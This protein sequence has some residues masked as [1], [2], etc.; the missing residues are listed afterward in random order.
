MLRDQR[1]PCSRLDPVRNDSA[2]LRGEWGEKHYRGGGELGGAVSTDE[3][4]NGPKVMGKGGRDIGQD[5]RAEGKG[6]GT[7]SGCDEGVAVS[8]GEGNRGHWGG[9]K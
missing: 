1:V 9:G 2:R 8:L 6:D 4:T 7:A 3:G 5:G